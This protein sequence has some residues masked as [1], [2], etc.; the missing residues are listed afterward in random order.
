MLNLLKKESQQKW[1]KIMLN[2]KIYYLVNVVQKQAK[3]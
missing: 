1:L 3:G 2:K